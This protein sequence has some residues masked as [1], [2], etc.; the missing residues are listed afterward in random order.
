MKRH[1]MNFI[2]IHI[3]TP[4]SE[5]SKDESTPF[6]YKVKTINLGPSTKS[7]E[8]ED[9]RESVKVILNRL[10]SENKEKEEL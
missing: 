5:K 3:P 10:E 1:E 7:Q 6:E 2:L 4:I 9:L 8:K